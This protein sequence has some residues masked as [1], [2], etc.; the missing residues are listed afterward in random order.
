MIGASRRTTAWELWATVAVFAVAGAVTVITYARLPGG[1][2]YHFA[3]TGLVDGGLSR[4]VS[5]LSFPVALAGIAWALIAFSVLDGIWRTLAVIAAVLCAVTA[6]PG[7]NPE[8]DLEAQWINAAPAA[9]ALAA[10]VLAL[11][12][13]AIRLPRHT[14]RGG[15]RLRLALAVL[16]AVWAI[17]WIAAALGLYASDAPLIGG[18]WN[19]RAP[20]PGEPDLPSVHRGL[21]EG[22][23]GVQLAVTALA[24][25][26]LLGAVRPRALQTSLSVYLAVMLCYGLMVTAQDG[27]N[28]QVVKRGWTSTALPNVLTPKLTLGWLGLLIGAA[29]VQ[30][31]WFGREAGA[32]HRLS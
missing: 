31:V 2:T 12:A 25:S 17:P 19:A 29:A 26:R 11:G 8:S 27:W 7:V 13:S 23:F 3:S 30:L 1:A 20:T 5:D 14:W 18:L 21:H 28:E 4:L 15:D 9:G 10:A 32:R 6:L 24:L 16:L 22:L